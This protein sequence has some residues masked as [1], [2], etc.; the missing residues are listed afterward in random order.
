MKNIKFNKLTNDD[1]NKLINSIDN[2]NFV[3][4]TAKTLF[5]IPR[6]GD[7]TIIVLAE[8]KNKNLININ[9]FFDSSLLSYSEKEIMLNFLDNNE[10]DEILMNIMKFMSIQNFEISDIRQGVKISNLKT[11]SVTEYSDKKHQIYKKLDSQFT[12][13]Y[14]KYKVNI[15][16][17]NIFVPYPSWNK[18]DEKLKTMFIG[19]DNSERDISEKKAYLLNIGVKS[20]SIIYS[21]HILSYADPD[22]ISYND[23]KLRISELEDYIKEVSLVKQALPTDWLIFNE[24]DNIRNAKLDIENLKIKLK[25]I[26]TENDSIKSNIIE[27]I[28]SITDT[29]K[30]N[31]LFYRI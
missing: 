22:Y 16:T 1:K 2:S 24:K 3:K 27:K 29:E 19:Y 28:Q 4:T 11:F 14:N 18:K 8:D 26:K 6:D 17:K 7:K 30:L 20:D 12:I 13:D 23:A 5:L 15:L 9:R 21:D 25:T 10:K 31:E